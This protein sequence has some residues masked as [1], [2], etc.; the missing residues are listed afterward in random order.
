MNTLCEYSKTDALCFPVV[1]NPVS[2]P[3]DFLVAAQCCLYVNAKSFLV[4]L[5]LL[6]SCNAYTVIH[7]RKSR[8]VEMWLEMIRHFPN[9]RLCGEDRL[10]SQSNI[11]LW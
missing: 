11:Q 3:L 10:I 1:L 6:K 5:S 8:G 7:S 4:Y 2:K 9:L